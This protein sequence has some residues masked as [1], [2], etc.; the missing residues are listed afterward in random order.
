MDVSMR[1]EAVEAARDVLLRFRREAPDWQ[2]DQTPVERIARWLG[3]EVVTFHPDDYPAGT[4]GFLEPGELLIWLCRDLSPA[5]RRFTLAHE[6]GHVV[7]HS[8]LPI[9]HDL[10]R[11]ASAQLAFSDDHPVSSGDPCQGQDISEEAAGLLSQ[12]QAEDL[13]GP[14]LA[15]DPRSRRELAANL[16]AAELLMPLERVWKLYVVQGNSPDLLAARFGVSLAAMFNRLTGLFTEQPEYLML[17]SSS[18]QA[19]QESLPEQ[20]EAVVEQ[21]APA[22]KAYDEFQRA[23]IETPTPALVVAGPGSGKT[24]TLIGRAEYLLREQGVL[25]EQILALTFSRKA[26][27]EM[28]ER[29]QKILSAGQLA[30]TISTFHA[31]CADLLRTHGQRLGL[32]QDFALVDDAEGYFLLRGLAG[33]LP[34]NHYQNLFDPA[35]PFRDFL[36]AISRAKDELITPA[37]YRELA[38]NML[39]QAG[40]EEEK[41]AAERALEIAAVYELYQQRLMSRGDSDFGGLLMLAVQLLSEHADIRSAILQRYQHIL[42]DEFQDINRASGILLRLLA[43]EKKQIWVVGDANQSIYGFRGAS[44]ANIGQFRQDYPEAVILPLSRNYRSR[45]DIVLSADAFKGAILEQDERIGAVQTARATEFDPY[46]TLAVAPDDGSELRGLVRDIQHK[47]AEG[48]SCRDVV[49][50]CRTRS[51]ARK[52]TRE[53]ARVGLPTGARRG[54]MEQEHT[55]NILSLLLLMVNSS[56]MGLLRAARL[57][58]HPLERSDVEALLLDVRARQT[59]PFA[60]LFHEEVPLALSSEGARSWARLA[61]IS[62]N[63]LHN[64][65]SVWSLLARYLMLETSMGR[66]LLLAGEDRQARMMRADYAS[67]LQFAHTY[68][69]R[70]QEERRQRAAQLAEPEG[71]PLSEPDLQEQI[72]GFLDY[73]QIL[74]SLRQEIEGKRDG[75]AEEAESAPEQ[76]R[77]MT[78]HASKGLEFPVVYLPGL[79]K[80][81]FPL[82]RRPNATPPPIGMLPPESEGERA[83]ESGEACLF[84]V[85]ATRARDQLIL[86]Y[87]DRHGKQNAKRSPYVDA[88]IVGL[89][90]ERVRRVSWQEP[91]EETAGKHVPEV[92]EEFEG[93]TIAQPSDDFITATQPVKLKTGQIQDYLTCP[94]RYAYSTLYSFR[95]DD[96]TFL[97]FWQASEATIK[98][99]IEQER[100][101]AEAGEPGESGTSAQT[102]EAAELFQH[103]WQAHGDESGPFAQLYI[104]HGQEIAGRLQ[105]QL[106]GEQIGDWQLRQNLD[107]NLAGHKVEVTID[108]VEQS[109]AENQPAKFVRTRYGK[110]KSKANPGMRELFYIH[111]GRQHHAGQEIVLQTHNLS[112]GEIQEIKVSARKEESLLTDFERAARG[113]DS[114]DYPPKPDAF[115]CPTCPFYLICPA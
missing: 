8:H 73:L 18:N 67:L 48:Y 4:F 61:G 33:N 74:L 108:R 14:G 40:S 11:A 68:S 103:Y 112:T 32:R 17:P 66:D 71:E 28:Q 107:V 55:K 12:Q 54:M 53:L 111:A 91:A 100:K 34:L 96:G 64:S 98:A 10:P 49:V 7:L 5:F 85:G 86:S 22:R 113:I 94:R 56:G 37:R 62:K 38:I 26:A 24:S 101:T 105:N 3:C 69:Q 78:V 82:G 81:R 84:Y 20:A 109:G 60:M 76:L 72:R 99:L 59:S 97:P 25:P 115:T 114:H 87:S 41:Q 31:F 23:A 42:V 36:K 92:E 63:L 46:V 104:Q 57:P 47:L 2:D 39:N 90:E 52:V 110:S 9:G 16:F 30:P 13:L 44:P 43:G 51:V 93:A 75:D 45:P 27:Q 58:A 35:S 70:L 79:T 95:R 65:S 19:D 21:T 77:V 88:L 83:H 106:Q 50:L 15:Y 102:R 80:S 6:L 89:P 1:L 29:L